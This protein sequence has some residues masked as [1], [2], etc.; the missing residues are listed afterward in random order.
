MKKGAPRYMSPVEVREALQ[1]LHEREG[2]WPNV[3]KILGIPQGT[4]YNIAN[5]M[6]IKN[7]EYRR[8]LGLEPSCPTCGKVHRRYRRSKRI[9]D[10]SDEE[11]LWALEHRKEI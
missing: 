4:L 11:L 9:A 8:I 2:S 10:M 1:K 6:T 3:S 5:G 7:E